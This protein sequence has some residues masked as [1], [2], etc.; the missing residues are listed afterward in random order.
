[1]AIPVVIETE[2]YQGKSSRSANFG[3][4]FSAKL[5]RTL[6]STLYDYKIEACIREYATNVTDSHIDSGKREL[7]GKIHLPT[8][9]EPWYEAEDFG[10]GM[11]EDTIYDIFTVFGKSTKEHDNSTSGQLGLGS[12][13]FLCYAEQ[14]TVT[15]VKDGIKA[16]VVCYKDRTGLPT[17]DTKS[18][19]NTTEPNGTKVRVP[20]NTKDI[21]QWQLNGARVLGAFEVPHEVNTFGNYA[22]EYLATKAICKRAREE[23][24]VYVP[25]N[26]L[27][28]FDHRDSRF[29]LMGDV[30]YAI[31]SWGD[32][33]RCSKLKDVS[34]TMTT[35]GLYI[36]HF[37]IGE[38][39]FAPSRETLSLDAQTFQKVSKRI[40]SD[41]IKYYRKLMSDVGSEESSS[42]YLFYNKFKG[43]TVWDALR[44]YKLPFTKGYLLRYTG[45]TLDYRGNFDGQK[46]RFLDGYMKG[47]SGIVPAPNKKHPIVFSSGVEFLHQERL[48]RMKDV[49]LVFS[50]NDK[51]LTKK[52]ETM[53]AINELFP[54]SNTVLYCPTQETLAFA[55]KW[56]GVPS[57]RIVCGD[58]YVPVKEK[59][60]RVKGGGRS[61]FGI[62]E[63]FHTVAQVITQSGMEFVKVD[64]SEEGVYYADSNCVNV[65]G[66]DAEYGFNLTYRRNFDKIQGLGI[67]KVIVA[68]KTNSA[69][70]KRNGV[71]SLE[72]H[73]ESLVKRKATMMAKRRAYAYN[74]LH[75][76]AKEK[77]V[78]SKVKSFTKLKSYTGKVKEDSVADILL[79][80]SDFGVHTL[81]QYQ[82]EVNKVQELKEKICNEM[83]EIKSKLPLWDCVSEKDFNYYLKLEKFIK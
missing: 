24:S 34:T 52:K 30:L 73:L 78:A 16:V 62:T 19:T 26:E 53:S 2:V 37:D 40:T 63:E 46:I 5:A 47:V 66:F 64:L 35:N 77:L 76:S 69:K 48:S 75:L 31:P 45:V 13:S 38:C 33:V 74:T 80:V 70:I 4:E 29:V 59:K 72:K 44:D 10:L 56:F 68:N 25:A 55:T 3:M 60:P 79:G 82:Q 71:P 67:N 42:W 61:A 49:V 21:R 15:S 1:M 22:D 17:A 83:R 8:E 28:D 20:V 11:D 65:K 81:P 43:S 54:D 50:E 57:E 27:G 6:S 14:L 18:I 23:K 51:G 41:I 12:K 36:T 58:K 9:M 39:D 32:L 7:A